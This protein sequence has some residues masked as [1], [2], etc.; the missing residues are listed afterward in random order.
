MSRRKSFE[1]RAREEVER[2]KQQKAAEE[3]RLQERMRELAKEA[4]ER[5]EAEAEKERR[6]EAE[7]QAKL[8]SAQEEGAQAEEE[9]VKRQMFNS[10]VANGGSPGE[11]EAAWPNLRREMLTQ[12]TLKREA[13][14][15]EA[16]RAA[17]H[18][19]I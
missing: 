13:G 14:A 15:R 18:S 19:R 9:R 17:S 1:E 8:R 12:R 10:W 7:R 4:R 3:E 16:H 11:F 5:R 6:R 2:I